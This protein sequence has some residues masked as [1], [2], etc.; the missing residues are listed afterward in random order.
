MYDAADVPEVYFNLTIGFRAFVHEHCIRGDCKQVGIHCSQFKVLSIP[1][2]SLPRAVQEWL[3]L[4]FRVIL[5]Q[6]TFC[7]L[8]NNRDA[9]QVVATIVLFAN[10]RLGNVVD[11]GEMHIQVP[12]ILVDHDIGVTF[13]L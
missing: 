2:V 7:A 8:H 9:G 13:I 11:P 4:V 1:Q 10:E 5:E 12:I 3:V 6:E